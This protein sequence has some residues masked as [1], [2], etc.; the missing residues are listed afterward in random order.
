MTVSQIECFL[1]AARSDSFSAAARAMYVTQPAV[2]K[3][4]SQMERELGFELFTRT[5]KAIRLSEKGK[6]LYEVLNSSYERVTG[7]LEKLKN[8]AGS[9][10][11]VFRLGCPVGWDASVFHDALLSRLKEEDPLYEL[12]IRACSRDEVERALRNGD[13]DAVLSGGSAVAAIPGCSCEPVCEIHCGILYSKAHFSGKRLREFANADF[14][15]PCRDHRVSAFDVVSFLNSNKTLRGSRLPA[16]Y[17]NSIM[18]TLCGRGVM[19][20]DQLDHHR[21]SLKLGFYPV[22]IVQPVSIS[23]HGKSAGKAVKLAALSVAEACASE[24]VLMA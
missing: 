16:K 21:S 9:Q 6:E 12:Q 20:T 2:S 11:P 14:F 3:L 7:T 15:M 22:D 24:T 8:D 17:N 18:G 1:V 5:G 4:I 23:F 13:V 10:C 19:I